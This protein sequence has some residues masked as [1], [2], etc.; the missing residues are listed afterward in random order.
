MGGDSDSAM[1]EPARELYRN[2]EGTLQVD[3]P[4]RS[5]FCSTFI[6]RLTLT[7]RG[8][9]RTRFRAIS[10][11]DA[12]LILLGAAS[13]HLYS[14][15]SPP[16]YESTSIVLDAHLPPDALPNYLQQAVASESRHS[17]LSRKLPPT[18]PSPIPNLAHEIPQTELVSHAPGWTIFRNLYMAEGT[19]FIVTSNPESFPDIKFMTSTGLPALNTPESIAERMPTSRDMSVISSDEAIRRW[20]GEPSTK[21]PNQVFPIEGSTVCPPARYSGRRSYMASIS[22]FSTTLGNVGFPCFP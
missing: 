1:P 13:M 16:S 11:R 10:P 20:G 12:I 18:S 21:E 5:S 2:I 17:S 22:S 14:S 15:F 4:L 8:A 9:F 7:M 6:P 3:A 19:L